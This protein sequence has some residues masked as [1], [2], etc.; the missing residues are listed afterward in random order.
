MKKIIKYTLI[1]VLIFTAH[2]EAQ[3]QV[4]IMS[5]NFLK[6]PDNATTR[7]EHLTEVI[8]AV[9]PDVLVCQE[10][11]SSSGVSQILSDVLPSG[12]KAGT[13]LDGNG[14]DTDNAIFYKDSLIE[15]IDHEQFVADPRK[16]SVFRIKNRFTPD[17][18]VI[19]GVHLKASQG[20]DNEARRED[21]AIRIRFLTN[22]LSDNSYF[23][24][25]GDFNIYKS[26]E[27]AFQTLIDQST[28]NYFVDPLDA[29]GTWNNNSNFRSIHTQSTREGSIGDGGASGG[30]DDRFDIILVSQTI[31][32]EGGITLIE[33]SYTPFGNDGK[34]FNHSINTQPND[35]VSVS[36]ANSLYFASDHLPVYA[37]FEFESTTSIAIDYLTHPA[38]YILKQNYPNPFN[39]ETNITFYSPPN[40]HVRLIVTNSLGEIVETVFEGFTE[41]GKNQFTFKSD[42]LSSGIYFYILHTPEG[43]YSG[44]MLLLK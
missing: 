2:S 29:N 14:S 36:I 7:N 30:L 20:S 38:N 4:R 22:K 37:D 3:E 41:S 21:S 25:L 11:R 19:F 9:D 8:A 42:R 1:C 5:Y 18:L 17:T 13:F 28:R 33:D 39:P 24:T 31:M 26:S 27:P 44:K 43:I 35:A 12:Y 6:Y 23:I 10:I 16:I 34:H 40:Q 32:N 15:F